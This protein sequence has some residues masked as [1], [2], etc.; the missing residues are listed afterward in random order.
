MKLAVN[1]HCE[2]ESF[3]LDDISFRHLQFTDSILEVTRFSPDL[4]V[5]NPILLKSALS[6]MCAKRRLSLLCK[7]ILV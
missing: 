5:K 7:L 1:S 2:L 6:V 4:H 3:Y